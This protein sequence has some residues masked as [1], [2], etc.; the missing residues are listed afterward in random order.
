MAE[1][2]ERKLK[3]FTSCL[4]NAKT[5]NAESVKR[6]TDENKTLKSEVSSLK[7]QLTSIQKKYAE[8]LLS[9]PVQQESADHDDEE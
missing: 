3:E 9:K 4:D 5:K 6:L 8:L 2:K 7:K 1:E